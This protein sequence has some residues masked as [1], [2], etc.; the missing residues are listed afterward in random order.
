[1]K[2]LSTYGQIVRSS[3][4]EIQTMLSSCTYL[5]LSESDFQVSLAQSI[6]LR[7][8][9]AGLL[10]IINFNL[11]NNAGIKQSSIIHTEYPPGTSQE[12]RFDIVLLDEQSME[13][14][15][16]WNKKKINLAIELKYCWG[17]DNGTKYRFLSDIEKIK[18]CRQENIIEQGVVALLSAETIN[19][20]KIEEI[21]TQIGYSIND[22]ENIYIVTPKKLYHF[23]EM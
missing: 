23:N 11:G 12:N 10:K 13:S 22:L 9:K 6:N 15:N 2:D 19:E 8:T 3:I 1:M 7:L 17:L 18:K 20:D 4:E 14:K 16:D 5:F 21:K